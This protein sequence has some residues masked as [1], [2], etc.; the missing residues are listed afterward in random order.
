MAPDSIGEEVAG[1]GEDAEFAEGGL[2]VKL[3]DLG[4]IA[5]DSEGTTEGSSGDFVASEVDVFPSHLVE[6]GLTVVTVVEELPLRGY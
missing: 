4:I 2:A 1:G 3:D 5:D 6:L